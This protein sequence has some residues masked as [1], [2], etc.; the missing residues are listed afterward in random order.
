MGRHGCLRGPLSRVKGGACFVG[1]RSSVTTSAARAPTSAP[2]HASRWAEL[3]GLEERRATN[4][5]VAQTG[6][7]AAEKGGG[8]DRTLS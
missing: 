5:A 4:G 2:P 3:V 7:H 1:S 6:Q 8:R